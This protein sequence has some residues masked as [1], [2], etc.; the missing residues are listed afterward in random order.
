[1]S[2]ARGYVIYE[3]KS[4]LNGENIVAIVTMNST[5]IKTGNMASMWIL[6]AD[7]TPTQASKEGKDESVCGD[8]KHRAVNKG[9]CYVT[10]FHA[11]LQ[12]YKSYKKGN[13]PIANDM[14]IFEGMKVR[15]GA[16]GDPSAI[17]T[18]ILA[19]IKAVVKNNTS[20]THQWKQGDKILKRVSMASVDSI[21]EQKQA[22]SEG[23]RTFR[24]T[25]D[26]SDKL[27][28]EIVCPNT[29][30]AIQCA[31]CGLCSGT[32]SKAKNIVIEVHGSKKGNFE[33][34]KL[35]IQQG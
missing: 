23:W 17:P 30:K 33:K 12:V 7:M 27:A 19:S 3:G 24:V 20:Y 32:S 26:L 16:Y 15:F 11:P 13:Y 14:T 29:T 35:A 5:N 21:A 31:D 8:C 2:K 6:N 1:M 22:V 18:Q 4:Q 9:A 34:Q 10:L 25:S 28:N